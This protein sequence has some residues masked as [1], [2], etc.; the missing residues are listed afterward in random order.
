MLHVFQ[1]R[2]AV[3]QSETEVPEATRYVFASRG[4]R[5][6]VFECMLRVVK[7]P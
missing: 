7:A 6:A 2:E 3:E 1:E 4:C 5:C